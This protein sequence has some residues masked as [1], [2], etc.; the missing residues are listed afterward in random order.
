MVTLRALAPS[1]TRITIAAAVGAALHIGQG[2]C[3]LV[4]DQAVEFSRAVLHQTDIEGEVICCEGPKDN[5]PSFAYKE[6]VGTGKG[7]KV[8]F[9][10]DPVDGT[11]AASKGRKDAISALACAPAG[12]FQVLP[13]DGYYFKIATS[14]HSL[15]KI[16]ADM[17]IEE[18][19]HTVA[20]HKNVPL[21]N[22]TV[23][24]LD[25]D[26]HN[27]MLATLRK[28]GVRIILIPDGDIAGAVVSCIPNSGVDLLLGAGAGPEATIA[29]TAVKCL[30]GTMLVKVWKDKKDDAKRLA[31]LEKVGV[32]VEK[33]YNQDELAKGN[34]LVFAA[35]GVTKGE[36]L[37]GVRLIP[38]G[39]VV[40]SICMRLPSGT[41]EKSETTLRFKG[42]PVYKQFMPP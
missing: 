17:T 1:L 34:E 13:D 8:E 38:N 7:P 14:N 4:D 42:H 5:A 22:F 12:C 15:G 31:R 27:Q 20:K 28:L 25:R 32:D 30:G 19:V 35:S 10:I 3:D 21:G 9:V 29:A 37:D 11:T 40:Y 41:V 18:I 6:K 24:M 36:L 16:S 33:T 39:A 2:N 23:I 26:R